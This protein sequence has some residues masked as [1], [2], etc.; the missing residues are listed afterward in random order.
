MA[1][2]SIITCA[3]VPNIYSHL[4][5]STCIHHAF[6]IWDNYNVLHPDVVDIKDPACS[7]QELQ[8]WGGCR[9][10][11]NYNER[12]AQDAM[13]HRF[14]LPGNK[15]IMEN[16][17]PGGYTVGPHSEEWG[18][19]ETGERRISR[20]HTLSMVKGNATWLKDRQIKTRDEEGEVDTS[21]VFPIRNLSSLKKAMKQ[22]SDRVT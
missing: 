15:G 1:L 18:Q 4:S 20:Q 19:I 21:F 14:V 7:C 10:E 5:W 3:K 8:I 2:S 12:E 22:L 9:L 11:N 16:K 6:A 17:F 13:E